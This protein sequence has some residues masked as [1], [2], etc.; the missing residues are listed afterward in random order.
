MA[1]ELSGYGPRIVEEDA[2]LLAFFNRQLRGLDNEL[3]KIAEEDVESKRLMTIPGVGPLSAVAVNCWIG[4]IER[5]SKAKK[6]SSYFGLAPRVR[7]SGDRERHGHI[8]KEDNRMVRSLLIQ[9]ALWHIRLGKGASRKHSLECSREEGNR[10][11]G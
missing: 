7:Q 1:K 2:E 4:T 8:T 6:L 9:A 10:L 5:F 3:Q 11:P